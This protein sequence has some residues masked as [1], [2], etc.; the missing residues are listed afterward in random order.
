LS[1]VRVCFSRERVVEPII[2]AP[3]VLAA[4]VVA[5]APVVR[6]VAIAV[7][8][9]QQTLRV[10]VT[11]GRTH[12]GL[13]LFKLHGSLW[14]LGS[15][16]SISRTTPASSTIRTAQLTPPADASNG[17][18]WTH[19]RSPRAKRG[20]GV[21]AR[22]CS[23]ERSARISIHEAH[24]RHAQYDENATKIATVTM[25]AAIMASPS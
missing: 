8:C 19:R 13:Q 24:K 14:I 2:R 6:F 9:E 1:A 7:A 3:F 10:V 16:G 25:P 11:S 4:R 12:A 20:G 21:E 22:L 17:S 15:P 18:W 23:S 5:D